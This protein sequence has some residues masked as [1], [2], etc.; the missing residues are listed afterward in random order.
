MSDTLSDTL[1]HMLNDKH[2]Y[3]YKHIYSTGTHMD[4]HLYTY[5]MQVMLTPRHSP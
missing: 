1:A 3:I 2:M 5:K 4:T